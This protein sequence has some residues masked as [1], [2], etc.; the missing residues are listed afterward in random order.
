[1]ITKHK[2]FS[3]PVCVRFLSTIP[4]PPL[5]SPRNAS[6]RVAAETTGQHRFEME[7]KK[8]KLGGEGVQ[9]PPKPKQRHNGF[10]SWSLS[11]K[12]SIRVGLIGDKF[13]CRISNE[14]D[15]E[16]MRAHPPQI[17]SNETDDFERILD[18]NGDNVVAKTLFL[19]SK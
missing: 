1:M 19:T 14:S 8:Q 11:L 18:E 3:Y 2:I 17:F 12:S 15:L 13:H 16:E 9:D 5:P 4:P 10:K 6:K 7:K